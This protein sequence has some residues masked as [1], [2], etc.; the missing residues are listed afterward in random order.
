GLAVTLR[1]PEGRIL[2]ST[3]AEH[4]RPGPGHFEFDTALGHVSAA[5]PPPGPPPSPSRALVPLVLILALVGISAV[6]TAAWLGR[7]LIV[8]SN[9]ARALGA[10]NLASRAMLRRTEELGAV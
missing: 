5:L 8:L 9:A 6:F 1:D 10:G 7:P 2:A 3:G 4:S